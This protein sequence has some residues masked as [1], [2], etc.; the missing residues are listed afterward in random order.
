MLLA[1]WVVVASFSDLSF[2]QSDPGQD[3]I[4]TRWRTAFRV[5]R[6]HADASTRITLIR[7]S[8][9]ICR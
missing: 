4:A 7:S 5:Y 2:P 6:N 9:R 8:G 3:G 1:T